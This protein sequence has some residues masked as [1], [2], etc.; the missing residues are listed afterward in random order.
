MTG[1]T[2]PH[3]AARTMVPPH[4]ISISQVSSI[5]YPDKAVRPGSFLSRNLLNWQSFEFV[6]AASQPRR[7]G[8]GRFPRP[9]TTDG[10]LF[11]SVNGNCADSLT[12]PI[13]H[14]ILFPAGTCYNRCGGRPPSGVS[15]S[16][17]YVATTAAVPCLALA[18][19]EI[20]TI[21]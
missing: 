14:L 16:I 5:T 17:G 20:V 1:F 21:T 12:D 18:R 6:T 7:V 13:Q 4:E 3:E 9:N 8:L 11:D 19:L 15:R 2:W 10:V